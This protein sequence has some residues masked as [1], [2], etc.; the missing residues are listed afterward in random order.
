V[1]YIESCVKTSPFDTLGLQRD[2]YEGFKAGTVVLEKKSS[3]YGS[4]M[5]LYYKDQPWAFPYK[6]VG[7]VMKLFYKEGK[8]FRLL[9]FGSQVRRELPTTQ[10]EPVAAAHVNGGYTFPCNPQ[11][12]VVYRREE[13]VRV[14]I[15]ECYHASCSDP[16][17]IDLPY[18]EADTEAW[19][20]ITLCALAAR[21]R[22]PVFNR[23]FRAQIEYA[24]GQCKMLSE[25]YGV[26]VPSDYA[27]RYTIGKL[28][29][30][31]ALG[32][33]LPNGISYSGNSLRLTLEF[34]GVEDSATR[35]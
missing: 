18:V 20:E 28:N 27:W 30:W 1:E 34:P 8:P 21:G 19:A 29:R 7:S 6:A 26:R 22:L 23:L 25:V 11:T 9:F 15:H 13:V 33:K 10:D 12:I 14:L 24:R 31:R 2:I 32:F 16:Q 3:I 17:G 5:V 4:V 35:K